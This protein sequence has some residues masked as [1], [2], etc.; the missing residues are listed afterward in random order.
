LYCSSDPTDVDAYAAGKAA[1]F[2][3]FRTLAEILGA[4][5]LQDA[6]RRGVSVMVETS[7]RDVASLTYLDYFFGPI[8][9]RNP[10]DGSPGAPAAHYR[11][12]LVH[13]TVN[14]IAA[15]EASVD[16][17]MLGEISRGA[18]VCAAAFP[19]GPPLHPGCAGDIRAVIDVN[20]GGP[21]GSSVLA[22]VKRDSDQVMQV[23]FGDAARGSA[24]GHEYVGVV[25]DSA[26]AA[27]PWT[28]WQKAHICIHAAGDDASWTARG[29]GTASDTAYHFQR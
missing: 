5:L 25:A 22:G 14:D 27:S 18:A 21:Y 13:F 12:L 29:N 16:S 19:A 26:S 2:A 1:I 17:R 4:V 15:A 8:I 28:E 24:A 11:R 9:A 20:A 3:R 7:G 6:R 10:T 23:V